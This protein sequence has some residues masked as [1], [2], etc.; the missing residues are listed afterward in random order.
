ML[1]NDEKHI[2][3][4]AVRTAE[5]LLMREQKA[6]SEKIEQLLQLP[7]EIQNTKEFE[8][9]P[10]GVLAQADDNLNAK[11][12]LPGELDQIPDVELRGSLGIYNAA[13]CQLEYMRATEAFMREIVHCS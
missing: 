5:E 2:A 4:Q 12:W 6:L 11:R 9:S 13:L 1:K 3:L 8:N 7:F 10:A